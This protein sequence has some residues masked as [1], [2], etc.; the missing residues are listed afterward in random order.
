MRIW[1]LL[2]WLKA[3]LSDSSAFKRSSANTLS[4]RTSASR[5]PKTDMSRSSLQT[6]DSSAHGAS[7][8]DE[9]GRY[10]RLKWWHQKNNQHVIIVLIINQ[11]SYSIIRVGKFHMLIIKICQFFCSDWP[12]CFFQAVLE[13]QD[14]EKILQGTVH[15]WNTMEFNGPWFSSIQNNNNLPPLIIDGSLIC[16]ESV[17]PAWPANGASVETL[18]VGWSQ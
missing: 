18:W 8:I 12:T 1:N 4:G 10:L 15:Q 2:Q 16:Q 11:P 14:V 9:R 5:K 17:V 7:R 3:F 13:G 6:R